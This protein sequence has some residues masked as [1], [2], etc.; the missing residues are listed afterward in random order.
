MKKLRA[1]EDPGHEYEHEGEAEHVYPQDTA[2]ASERAR[3]DIQ[4]AFGVLLEAV[5]AADYLARLEG[6]NFDPFRVRPSWKLPWTMWKALRR[7]EI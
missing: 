2:L 3:A 5:P 1:G 6:T 7:R 4:R